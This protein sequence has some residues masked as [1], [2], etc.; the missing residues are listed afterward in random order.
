MCQCDTTSLLFYV[1]PDGSHDLLIGRLRTILLIVD[2]VVMPTLRHDDLL[3]IGVR[4]VGNGASGPGVVLAIDENHLL[5]GVRQEVGDEVLGH[6]VA[7]AC[8]VG[9]RYEKKN[10]VVNK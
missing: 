2:E 8:C 9:G 4:R 7:V 3:N 5:G 1:F 10:K 6:R